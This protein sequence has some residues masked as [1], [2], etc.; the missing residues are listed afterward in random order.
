MAACLQGCNSISVSA[1]WSTGINYE[2]ASLLMR[3]ARIH[4]AVLYLSMHVHCPF[5]ICPCSLPCSIPAQCPSS[6]P[7]SIPAQCPCSL[8]CSI[9]ATVYC[10]VLHWRD[11]CYVLYLPVSLQPRMPQ[12]T[13]SR[14][15]LLREFKFAMH[16]WNGMALE[17]LGI[18]SK[19]ILQSEISNV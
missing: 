12:P 19:T 11:H 9:L 15:E 17:H 18:A 6:L 14:Q 10:P 2:S 16:S 13:R 7:Y 1:A 8:P 5:Y 4:C 3:S